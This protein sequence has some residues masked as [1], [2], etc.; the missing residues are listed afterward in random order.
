MNRRSFLLLSLTG[1]LL[2]PPV[3]S[4]LRAATPETT[5]CAKLREAH[6]GWLIAG[7]LAGGA[8]GTGSLV[9]AVETDQ[10][11]KVGT[12]A[13]AGVLGAGAAVA[14]VLA[15]LDADAYTQECTKEK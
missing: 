10:G 12:V 1:C 11:Q 5:S 15:G 13:A 6:N 4:G 9:V 3:A 8:A 2:R 7:A 14:T